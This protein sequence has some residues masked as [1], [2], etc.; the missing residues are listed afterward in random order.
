MVYE[1]TYVSYYSIEKLLSFISIKARVTL[2]IKKY[3]KRKKKQIYLLF[4]NP[5]A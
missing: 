2:P 4:S 1:L 3:L 5:R